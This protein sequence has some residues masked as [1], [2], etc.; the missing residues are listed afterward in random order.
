MPTIKA[1]NMIEWKIEFNKKRY[2]STTNMSKDVLQAPTKN[3]VSA[4]TLREGRAEFDSDKRTLF[5]RITDKYKDTN[6]TGAEI[7]D[8]VVKMAHID[9]DNSV[10]LGQ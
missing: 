10:T 4:D 2:L 8:Y 9:R 3:P 1:K 6:I 5:N 7:T